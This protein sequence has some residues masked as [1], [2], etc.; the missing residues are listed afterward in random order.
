MN[1]ATIGAT[2]G[3]P[4]PERTGA[5]TDRGRQTEHSLTFQTEFTDFLTAEG[6]NAKKPFGK[7]GLVQVQVSVVAGA[8]NRCNRTALRCFV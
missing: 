5:N 3:L 2:S 4:P 7:K 1:L 6:Q 8:D